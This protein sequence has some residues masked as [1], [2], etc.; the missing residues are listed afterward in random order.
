MEIPTTAIPELCQEWAK[1]GN[2]DLAHPG[3]G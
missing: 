1:D 2:E 3:Q